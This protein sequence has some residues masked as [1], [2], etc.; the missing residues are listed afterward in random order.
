MNQNSF[1]RSAEDVRLRLSLAASAFCPLV[2]CSHCC[3][4]V[5]GQEAQCWAG[6]VVHN[7]KIVFEAALAPRQ[8]SSDGCTPV[9]GQVHCCQAACREQQQVGDLH[10]VQHRHMVRTVP[11]SHPPI[12]QHKGRKGCR[13]G[14]Q[15]PQRLCQ[16]RLILDVRAHFPNIRWPESLKGRGMMALVLHMPFCEPIRE[17]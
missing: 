17:A 3:A 14:C 1:S 12:P 8:T 10:E 9:W 11:H 6:R 5:C 4:R 13:N 2:C 15:A 7:Q 16:P